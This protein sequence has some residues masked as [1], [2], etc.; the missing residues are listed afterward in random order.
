MIKLDGPLEILC[1]LDYV[2]IF[3]KMSVSINRNNIGHTEK[4]LMILGE[5]YIPLSIKRVEERIIFCIYSKGDIVILL[6]WYSCANMTFFQ[7]PI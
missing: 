2:L 3:D 4:N 7:F 5:A 6:F 1:N